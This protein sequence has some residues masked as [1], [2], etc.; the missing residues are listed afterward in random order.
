MM[1][2]RSGTCVGLLCCIALTGCSETVLTDPPAPP[3]KEPSNQASVPQ[4]HDYVHVV[5]QRGGGDPKFRI[6]VAIIR[7]EDTIPVHDVPFGD[8]YQPLQTQRGEVNIN[9]EINTSKGNIVGG[10]RQDGLGPASRHMLR[11][12]LLESGAFAVIER[13]RI[14][15]ILREIKFSK[16]QYAD[17]DTAAKDGSLIAVRYLIDGRIGFAVAESK[18]PGSSGAGGVIMGPRN[19]YDSGTVQQRADMAMINAAA[20]DR[21][22]SK[23]EEN[24]RLTCQLAA[25]DAYTGEVATDVTGE[26][27]TLQAAIDD[28]VGQ[29]VSSLTGLD[30][31]VRVAAVAGDVVYLDV[32]LG[33]NMVAGGRF[34]IMHAGEP[35]RDQFNRVIGFEES[36][37]G[38]VEVVEVRD[39]MS[40][41]KVI[42]AGNCARGDRATPIV[43]E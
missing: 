25:F 27:K 15:E 16:T 1:S 26:G 35:V 42:T 10:H 28:A 3:A 30:R 21:A 36:D 37:G 23:A 7:F 19:V 40:I 38:E 6:A 2:L 41:A 18:S 31:G 39:L 43:G 8:E 14:L 24:Y 13:E 34:R 20:R 17:P 4:A 33:A 12:S 29:L 11:R 5:R 32:G 9:V 22:R